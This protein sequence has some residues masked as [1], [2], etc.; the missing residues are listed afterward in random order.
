MKTIKIITFAFF[1]PLF[2]AC[3]ESDAVVEPEENNGTTLPNITGYPIVGTNQTDNYDNSSVISAP[4]VSD[5][6]YGQDAIYT[7][8]VPNYADN[9]DGTVT[10]MVTGLMWVQTCDMDGDGDI[11]ASDKKTS[12]QSLSGA[13][14]FNLG[15]YN[16]WRLPTIKELYSLILFS[17]VDTKVLLQMD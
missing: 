6:F 16:D 5:A 7:S 8:N 10:D 3:R 15:G 17:G 12:A 9:G 11:D 4:G 13:A 1:L 14:S 2:I